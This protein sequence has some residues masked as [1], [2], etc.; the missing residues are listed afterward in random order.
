M[1]FLHPFPA[2]MAPDLAVRAVSSTSN[3]L[4]VLDPMAG[5]GTA[6][7]S[8]RLHGHEGF[9][10]DRDPLAVLIASA[11]TR[12]LDEKRFLR[13]AERML[14]AAK[15]RYK[16]IGA[17]GAYP[18]ETDEETKRFIRYWFDLTSRRQL[19]ALVSELENGKYRT[20]AFLKVAISRMII[21]KQG[22]VSLAEDVSHSRPHR[23]RDL[24]PIKPFVQFPRSVK[25][26]VQNATFL[27]GSDLPT[28]S[29][30]RGDCRDLPFDD[31]EFDHIITSP[32]YL[33]AIDYLRGHKL[34]LVWFGYTVSDLRDLRATN[35][36]SDCGLVDHQL[37]AVVARMIDDPDS[38]SQRL[39]NTVRL[40]VSDLR[41][42]ISEM[43]RVLRPGGTALLVMGDCTVRGV[44]IRNSSAVH[45][46]ATEC[47]FELLS[48]RRRP[49]PPN[50]RYLPPPSKRS[51][52]RQLRRRMW[53]EVVL[54][55]RAG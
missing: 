14:A 13:E 23:T 38:V 54:R 51:S 1:R 5:S 44:D 10:V 47:G 24:S 30:I 25:A 55:Y 53:D 11:S 17:A 45:C 29:I 43:H 48:R 46:I 49:L 15:K 19:A 21:T 12:D 9:G 52:K 28:A 6:V 4:R 35:I 33:N 34:S 18:K 32:P 8:A 40:F 41:K 26:I 31:A 50:R 27:K 3:C 7:V 42:S 37:D 2:R 39:L 36:G 20:R 22:G 16:K